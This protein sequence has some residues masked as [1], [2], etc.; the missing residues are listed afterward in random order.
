MKRNSDVRNLI[1]A[2]ACLTGL[3]T[4]H[5]ACGS[6]ADSVLPGA[7][8]AKVVPVYP[9]AK[10]VGSMGG[11]STDGFGGAV[12]AKSQ[13]WFF[14]TSDPPEDVLAYYKKKMP[15]AEMGKDDVGDTTFTLIPAG[16]EEGERVQVILRKSGD[17]QIH[18]S[19]KPG[20]KS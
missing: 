9:G 2:A 3:M 11:Q 5:V 1:V 7:V 19:V 13:S 15:G 20:K 12:T 4:L 16:A 10:Y 8:Y 18:E 17:L 14:K 6:D